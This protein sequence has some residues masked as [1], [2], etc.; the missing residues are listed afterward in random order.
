MSSNET[1]RH[2][3]AGRNCVLPGCAY[4]MQPAAAEGLPAPATPATPDGEHQMKFSIEAIAR[5]THEAN[6]AVQIETGDPTPS[7]P[8][9][10]APQWQKDSAIDGVRN[11]I[12][13]GATPE[14]SHENW[15]RH[16]EADGW[17]YG[18]V[19]DEQA[20]THPCMVP[21]ADL[22]PE[23]R[24]KD[25][26][27]TGIVRAMAGLDVE[28]VKAWDQG[29]ASGSSNAMRRMSDEPSAPK[30]PNPYRTT[31]VSPEGGER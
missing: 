28:P 3:F 27:F 22:P 21:Y 8:W 20:K 5:T 19:K 1:H 25:D 24:V 16:K 18:E 4:V 13:N 31:V 30:T 11:V 23:Q 15:L 10:E 29:Y 17:V 12:E 7:P 14:Q 6:R 9:D 2:L 26:V